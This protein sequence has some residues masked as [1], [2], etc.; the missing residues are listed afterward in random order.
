[1]KTIAV[2]H[3]LKERAKQKR[4]ISFSIHPRK[5]MSQD[6]TETQLEEQLKEY[7]ERKALLKR[8]TQ[9]HAT[10]GE[11]IRRY[12]QAHNLQSCSLDNARVAVVSK[13]KI[14]YSDT[15]RRDKEKSKKEFADRE[16]QE[17]E[18]FHDPNYDGPLQCKS[19]DPNPYN[20]MEV[21]FG[22][23]GDQ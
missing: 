14:Q 6:W 5:P 19:Y 17:I 1:M 9:E 22:Q 2:R 3:H 13:T 8:L 7:V 10:Q 20:H 15:Y 21:S 23:G 11:L 18:N 4:R 12:Y 16:K